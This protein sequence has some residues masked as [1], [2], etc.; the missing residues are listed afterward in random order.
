MHSPAV[1]FKQLISRVQVHR[2]F[3]A[4][5]WRGPVAL[6]SGIGS[7]SGVCRLTKN[8]TRLWLVIGSEDTT[9]SLKY[10]RWHRPHCA[11]GAPGFL[12]M[13]PHKTETRRIE[14]SFMEGKAPSK[15]P[16]SAFAPLSR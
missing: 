16:A 12:A 7:S 2:A 1:H 15:A 11:T 10:V 14:A 4:T 5:T 6:I 3:P 13:P 9:K 8:H